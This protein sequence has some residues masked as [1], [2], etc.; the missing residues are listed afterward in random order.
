MTTN[1]SIER[2]QLNLD[3][4]KNEK[5]IFKFVFC[6]F[7]FSAL[8]GKNSTKLNKRSVLFTILNKCKIICNIIACMLY[9]LMSSSYNFS[10]EVPIK[11]KISFFITDIVSILNRAYLY[12]KMEELKKLSKTGTDHAF[13]RLCRSTLLRNWIYIWSLTTNISILLMY[14]RPSDNDK[15]SQVMLLGYIKETAFLNNLYCYAFY[16]IFANIFLYMPFNTFN[17]YYT[18]LCYDIKSMINEYRV[19]LK[20]SVAINYDKISSRYCK[21]KYRVKLIDSKVGVLVLIS[22]LWYSALMFSMLT[23]IMNSSS[24]KSANHAALFLRIFC[25][26]INIINFTVQLFS[27]SSVHDASLLV[28]DE[29]AIMKESNP[30]LTSSYLSFVMIH[31]EDV[32]MTVW[33]IAAI[34]KSFNIGTFGTILTYCFLFHSMATND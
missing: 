26:I 17:I 10:L 5:N 4:L 23:M 22:F 1:K 24:E 28:K 34:K 8:F 3:D 30:Q 9:I 11:L 19:I 18:I 21:I 25:S 6:L 31:N 20:S 13:N 32:C 7:S 27:A 2:T 33:G 15:K 14:V 12:K 16:S 29:I